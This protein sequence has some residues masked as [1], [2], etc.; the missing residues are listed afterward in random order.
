MI[1]VS[2]L[3]IDVHGQ[4]LVVCM[5]QFCGQYEEDQIHLYRCENTLMRETLKQGIQ[6]MEKKFFK[7]G[8][9]S[10][11]YLGLS[12]PFAMLFTFHGHHMHCTAHVH[13]GHLRDKSRSVVMHFSGVFIM[14]NGQ[15]HYNLRGY[16]P[17]DM[18]TVQWRRIETPYGNFSKGN[19][20]CK[21]QSFIA[22]TA[23]SLH[24]K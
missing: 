23:S 3:F 24:Q 8:M 17:G 9:A 10:P 21:M 1:R 6:D 2:Y 18:P 19:G 7:V 22:L 11:V 16:H 5:T 12:T 20:R 14:W 13:C 15:T 4:L